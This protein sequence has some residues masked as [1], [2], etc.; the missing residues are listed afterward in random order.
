MSG[1]SCSTVGAACGSK[2]LLRGTAIHIA[3]EARLRG[4]AISG[5]AL[6]RACREHLA[7]NSLHESKATASDREVSCLGAYQKAVEP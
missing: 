5:V 1:G 2:A 7:R 4:A 3:V 6:R